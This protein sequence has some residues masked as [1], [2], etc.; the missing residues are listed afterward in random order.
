MAFKTMTSWL[1]NDNNKTPNLESQKLTANKNKA[2]ED[3]F[4][5]AQWTLTKQAF[6]VKYSG[7]TANI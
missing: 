4:S 2:I 7:T 1:E 3:A 6:D 5:L